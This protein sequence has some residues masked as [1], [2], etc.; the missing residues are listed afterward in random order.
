MRIVMAGAILARGAAAVGSW[1]RRSQVIAEA[2]DEMI[3]EGFDRAV[4][5]H[6]GAGNPWD[7]SLPQL[8]A[9]CAEVTSLGA[10]IVLATDGQSQAAMAA[11]DGAAAVEDL[12]FKLGEGP[13]VDALAEGRPVL[14]HDLATAAS[15][16]MHFVPGAQALG[17]RAAFAYPLQVGAIRTGVL[18]LYADHAN[19]LGD[20]QLQDHEELADLVTTAL[21]AMQSGVATR[22]LGW[23]LASAAEYRAVV[24]Q[25]IGMV[26][27]QVE[28]SARDALARLRATAFT[29]GVGVDEVARQI[30]ERQLRFD[31]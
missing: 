7:L 22:E 8:C 16:W 18:S 31:R 11:S 29:E 19:P 14:V 10:S 17:V 13:G 24:H 5:A 21:L 20:G 3:A 12:Q 2:S 28:C 23:P 26:A 30:V 6:T 25:A 9:V 27:M 4:R 1:G 15:R